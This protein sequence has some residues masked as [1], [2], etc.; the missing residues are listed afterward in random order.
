MEDLSS[1]SAGDYTTTVTDSNGCVTSVSFT[2]SEPEILEVSA[3]VTDVSCNGL[4]D[5]SAAAVISGGNGIDYN[6]L[7]WNTGDT[8]IALEIFS[9][10]IIYNKLI[11][12]YFSVETWVNEFIIRRN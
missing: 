6:T 9:P 4:N 7:L 1:L 11:Q 3:S 10:I 2:V 5:G 8:S 12:L